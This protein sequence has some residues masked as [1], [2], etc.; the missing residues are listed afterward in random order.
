[1][2]GVRRHE[3]VKLESKLDVITWVA[4]S[5]GT[6]VSFMLKNI[7]FFLLLLQKENRS[8]CFNR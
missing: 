2:L 8:A 3:E 7:C 1:M 5:A 6:T 4:R